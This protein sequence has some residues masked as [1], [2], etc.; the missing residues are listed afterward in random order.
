MD[1]IQVDGKSV[2]TG[3][4]DPLNPPVVVKNPLSRYCNK[5]RTYSDNDKTECPKCFSIFDD[6]KMQCPVCYRF[7]DY[8][9]GENGNG[10]RQGC[11]SCWKPPER[12]V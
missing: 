7:F 12:K 4:E 2:F 3:K 8:L 5:C 11:E 9:V 6:G 10:G 1:V